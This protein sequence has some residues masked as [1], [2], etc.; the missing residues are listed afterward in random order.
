MGVIDLKGGLRKLETQCDEG[1]KFEFFCILVSFEI[2]LD[3]L[4]VVD[5]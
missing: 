3:N 1:Q 5:T 4:K 2:P